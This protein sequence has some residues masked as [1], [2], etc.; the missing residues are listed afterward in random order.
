MKPSVLTV[1]CTVYCVLL[2]D[3]LLC[4]LLGSKVSDCSEAVSTHSTV[5]CVLCTAV[6]CTAVC[7]TR[8]QGVRL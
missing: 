2:L 4:V 8:Q 6:R 5:Y 3:V 1:L 7:V